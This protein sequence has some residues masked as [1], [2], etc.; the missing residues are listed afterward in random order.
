[1]DLRS[2]GKGSG[3]KDGQGGN[4][5]DDGEGPGVPDPI[6][7]KGDSL[8]DNETD[9]VFTDAQGT[10]F[11]QEQIIDLQAQIESINES[12]RLVNM[13]NADT[14]GVRSEHGETSNQEPRPQ[15]ELSDNDSHAIVQPDGEHNLRSPSRHAPS[16]M[17]GHGQQLGDASPIDQTEIRDALPTFTGIGD[18]E[19]VDG[20]QSFQDNPTVVAVL[21]ASQRSQPNFRSRPSGAPVGGAEP[22][23]INNLSHIHI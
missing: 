17:E 6:G 22:L 14:G 9:E 10:S 5:S 1:M 16:S 21:A 23:G 15:G 20:S 8:V 18:S 13:G 4:S 11:H 12:F 19:N 7:D 2:G 3:S